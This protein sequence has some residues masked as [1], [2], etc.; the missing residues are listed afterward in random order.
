[1]CG[2]HYRLPRR[3]VAP[4]EA[5]DPADFAVITDMPVKSL[6]TSPCDGFVAEAGASVEVRGF[7]WSGHTPVASI[8]LSTDGG[9]SWRP[10]DLEPA[11]EKFAWRR[12][13][14]FV[15]FPQ[16]G[17]ASVISRA[18]DAAGRVQ[19]LGSAPWNPGGYCNNG[20]HEIVG[21]IRA[22]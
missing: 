1:M 21:T 11:A 2:I 19:P 14:G 12:F 6:I 18:T 10:A 15:R 22:P 7:A 16:T 5:I 3:P 20:T 17:P 9:A 8:D 13:R 4:G